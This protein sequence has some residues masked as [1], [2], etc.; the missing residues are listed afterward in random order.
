MGHSLLTPS[1][2]IILK[3]NYAAPAADQ[4]GRENRLH[5]CTYRHPGSCV[6][7][8][9]IAHGRGWEFLAAGTR[10]RPFERMFVACLLLNDKTRTAN[11][12]VK[13]PSRFKK[14]DLSRSLVTSRDK[15]REE[16][17]C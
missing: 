3:L 4:P 17:S 13:I 9:K 15:I 6:V 1:V 12:R 5:S 2:K 11:I 16:L 8:C 14:L 10:V 7:N